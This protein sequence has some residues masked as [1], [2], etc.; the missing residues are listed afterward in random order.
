MNTLDVAD[1]LQWLEYNHHH[2]R[3]AVGVGNDAT[4]TVQGILGITLRHHQGHIVV[5][6]E[7]T[8]VVN[9]HSTILGDG[10]GKLLRRTS[11]CRGEG[12]VNVLKVIVMLKQFNGQFLTTE[13]IFSSGRTLRTKQHQFVHWEISLVKQ[14]QEFLAYSA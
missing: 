1:V 7:S 10:L 13:S 12:N 2:N 9:H 5:H 14:A 11:T 4:R 3:R 6:T 8:G